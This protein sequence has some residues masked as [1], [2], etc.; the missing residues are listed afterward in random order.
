M[1]KTTESW[2]SARKIRT[3]A[4]IK[5]LLDIISDNGVLSI[6]ELRKKLIE[7]RI[8]RLSV[9][10]GVTRRRSKYLSQCA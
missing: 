8:Q 10:L 3:T 9:Y 7:R 6:A 4:E 2:G 5:D 1:I